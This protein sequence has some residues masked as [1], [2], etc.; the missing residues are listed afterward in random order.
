[1]AG[2][3]AMLVARS[4]AF[5]VFVVAAF[6]SAC[7]GSSPLMARA[8]AN[9]PPPAGAPGV[10]TVVFLRPKTF[11]YMQN[12]RIIDH[13]GRFV[14]EALSN[15]YFVVRPPPGEYVFV[16]G[17]EH[18]DVLYANVAPGFTYYVD[19]VPVPG[20]FAV[21][22]QLRPLRPG[23]REWQKLGDYL[24]SRQFVPLYASGQAEVDHDKGL[25]SRIER[26]KKMWADMPAQE[27]PAHSLGP[28]DGV[29]PAAQSNSAARP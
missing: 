23:E 15:G 3:K 2:R 14:G 9:A 5:L 28:T 7:T 16:V 8:P 18:I 17:D 21:K 25:R 26:A 1:M 6:V 29:P 12:F 22:A 19:V 13:A 11:G 4:R 24:R 20:S 27:R 10:A